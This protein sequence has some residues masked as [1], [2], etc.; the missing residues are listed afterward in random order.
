MWYPRDQQ[1]CP[2][3]NGNALTLAAVVNCIEVVKLKEAVVLLSA[4]G[5]CVARR[6]PAALARGLW[7]ARAV[8][9]QCARCYA[10]YTLC[11]IARWLLRSRRAWLHE[12]RFN[13]G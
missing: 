5:A 13:G 8:R 12:L 10:L 9:V 6:V 2:I 1:C 11:S 4:A 3:L 7:P